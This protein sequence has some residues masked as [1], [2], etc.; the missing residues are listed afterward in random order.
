M[1]RHMVY[2]FLW[3]LTGRMPSSLEPMLES[4]IIVIKVKFGIF[5]ILVNL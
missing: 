5:I 2:G 1:D 4:C 3:H